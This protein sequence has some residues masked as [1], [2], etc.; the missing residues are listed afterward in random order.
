MSGLPK[1]WSVTKI[2]DVAD[3]G[4]GATPKRGTKEF[5]ESGTIP[6]I[7]SGAVSQGRITYADEFITEA[8]IRS[9][10][11][12]VFPSGTILV[13]MYGEGKTRGSVARLAIDAATNQALAAIVLPNDDVVSGE[14]LMNFLTSQYSQLRGL[15]A[16]GVQPNLNLQLI[17]TT[18]FPLP[19]PPEQKR[20][21]GKLDA[22][23]AKSARARTEL[24]RIE[25]LVSRFKQAVLS[26][27]FNGELTKDWRE[28]TGIALSKLQKAEIADAIDAA[29]LAR[30]GSRTQ[31]HRVDFSIISDAPSSWANGIIAVASALVVGFAF[32]S[33]WYV[34]DGVK[35]LRG[36]NIAPRAIDWSDLQS[37]DPSRVN[38]FERYLVE[39]GDIVLAMDRPIISTGLKVAQITKQ[40]E[41]CLLVQ[42]V[43]RFRATDLVAQ[44]LL[45]WFL[46]AQIFLSHSLQR[47][48]G[49]DLPHISGDDISTCPI[50][51]PPLEEQ[52]E[53]VR[54]IEAA[55]AKI[56]RLAAEAKRALELVGK[57]DEAILSKAFRGELVPQDES[58]EPASALLERVRAEREAAPR[59]AR[60]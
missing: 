52:H 51:I 6:W 5:Y 16:G 49:S 30:R 4:T 11:C 19:P 55:F 21:V 36:A 7:T 35:L 29:L 2:Q 25:T 43:A 44:N 9:T 33:E 56:D 31:T 10:N 17:R 38:E 20:I 57:L 39:A 45:W 22:L 27:A 34:A 32:K 1:G 41:G 50:P 59:N 28:E 60:N 3:V 18:N 12:K 13:A 42:R 14:F 26:K 58:D 48:T 46:N 37:L 47:A 54:R 24:A 8:A 53:I 40:D 15:A 23:T